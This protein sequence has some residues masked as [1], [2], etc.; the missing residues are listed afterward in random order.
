MYQT[1]YQKRRTN[2]AKIL[3]RQARTHLFMKQQLDPISLCALE[4]PIFACV[5]TRSNLT[6]YLNAPVLAKHFVHSLDF[7]HP[8]TREPLHPLQIKQLRAVLGE[9]PLPV[10][11]I[12]QAMK[13]ASKSKRR[14]EEDTGVVDYFVSNL[15]EM[16]DT[17]IELATNPTFCLIQQLVLLRPG[18]AGYAADVSACVFFAAQHVILTLQACR[19][20]CSRG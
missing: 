7:R 2:A 20:R 9:P 19:V 11:E 13:S 17:G 15:H 16:V 5:C 3:Q 14:Q 12:I 6:T 4:Q 10:P 18:F 1:R 8:V